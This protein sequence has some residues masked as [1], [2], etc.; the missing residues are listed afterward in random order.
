M[1]LESRWGIFDGSMEVSNSLEE[2]FSCGEMIAGGVEV[3]VT[4]GKERGGREA[5]LAGLAG[6]ALPVSA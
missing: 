4:L 1:T 5:L 3:A 6:L 2:R